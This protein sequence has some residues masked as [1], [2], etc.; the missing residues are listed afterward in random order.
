MEKCPKIRVLPFFHLKWV[1]L[2]YSKWSE[3]CFAKFF[4]RW[5]WE[6]PRAAPHPSSWHPLHSLKLFELG[7]EVYGPLPTAP[8][9][10]IKH[11]TGVDGTTFDIFVSLTVFPIF[12]FLPV[13]V[14]S[15]L[16]TSSHW[17]CELQQ[18]QQMP[19][20]AS[21]SIKHEKERRVRAKL[22]FLKDIERPCMVCGSQAGKH[23]YYG[24]ETWEW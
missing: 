4:G 1:F 23:S 18:Q 5:C 13:V 7:G 9:P 3:T 20:L 24:G 19:S 17:S 22:G 14:W 12:S 11:D 2:N 16:D 15:A 6:R 8:Q 10:D 21:T